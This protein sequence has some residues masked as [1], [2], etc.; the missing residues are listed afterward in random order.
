MFEVQ[1]TEVFQDWLDRLRDSRAQKAISARIRRMTLGNI[2]DVKSVG[3]SVSEIRIDYGPGYRL[4]FMRRGAI[5][6]LLL[7]GGDK[8]SQKRDIETAV[9]MAKEFRGMR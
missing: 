4:Y 7:I 5:V 1:Q 6:L 2:G 3:D 8:K 9:A